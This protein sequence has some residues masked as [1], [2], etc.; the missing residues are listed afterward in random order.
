LQAQQKGERTEVLDQMRQVAK[1][2]SLA[3]A[4]AVR[5]SFIQYAKDH[6]ITIDPSQFIAIGR[7]VE[8]PKFSPPRTKE[9]WAANRR[10]RFVIKQVESEL[11]EFKPLGN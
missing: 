4:N 3:R 5:G 2:L 6:G 10:V 9:E 7:G 8:A 11:T 1:N